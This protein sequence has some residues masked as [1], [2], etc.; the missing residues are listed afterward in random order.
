MPAEQ[1]RRAGTALLLCGILAI[2]TCQL[3]G[4]KT[5]AVDTER[6][7][8]GDLLIDTLTKMNAYQLA[9]ETH[10]DAIDG[11]AAT[12]E[13]CNPASSAEAHRTVTK[14][15]E[16]LAADI[17]KHRFGSDI[18]EKLHHIQNEW[19]LLRARQERTWEKS[20]NVEDL[21]PVERC[22]Q[23]MDVATTRVE[24]DRDMSYILKA[25]IRTD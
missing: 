4:C 24:V 23:A 3:A 19:Q 1:G 16:K 13:L 17:P 21:E 14:L 12:S 10:R 7:A 8:W 11:R 22:L 9:L 2:G 18:I 20:A 25:F 15:L 6:L 5:D